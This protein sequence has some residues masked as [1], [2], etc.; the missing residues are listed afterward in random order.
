MRRGEGHSVVGADGP[1]QAASPEKAL[2]G[3]KSEIF[4]VR[5]QRFTQQLLQGEEYAGWLPE[6]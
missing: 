3:G 2:K 4:P 6:D 5:F 1:G